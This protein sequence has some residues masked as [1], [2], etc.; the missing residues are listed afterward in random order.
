MRRVVD[1]V[2]G[3]V[4][5]ASLHASNLM[6]YK[7]RN[8]KAQQAHK[9]A[10]EAAKFESQ[11][12]SIVPLFLNA[13]QRSGKGERRARTNERER[14]A[15]VRASSA[16]SLLTVLA[17]RLATNTS[18]PQFPPPLTAANGREGRASCARELEPRC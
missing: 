11:A 18:F 17:S 9:A 2:R 16:T 12:D 3:M 4:V 15:G 7:T 1:D 8:Q 14:R 13:A 5:S 10:G 6:I